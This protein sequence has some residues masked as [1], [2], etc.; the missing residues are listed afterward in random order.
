VSP[1][2]DIDDAIVDGNEFVADLTA[3]WGFRMGTELLLPEWSV[4]GDLQYVRLRARGGFGLEPSPLVA[5]RE[6]TL[7]LDAPRTFFTLGTGVETW[8]PFE[9]VDGPVWLDL[10][11]QYHTLAARALDRATPN[12]RAGFPIETS[13]IPIGGSIVVFGG[14]WGFQY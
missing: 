9:L 14:E 8:D 2:I 10:Y 6:D 7:L 3:V 5:Q 11:F 1:L 4:D 12:P 13:E